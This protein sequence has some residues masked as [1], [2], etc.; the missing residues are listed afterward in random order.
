MEPTALFTVKL[1]LIAVREHDQR[2][3]RVAT[4]FRPA[5]TKRYRVGEGAGAFDAQSGRAPWAPPQTERPKEV[6]ATCLYVAWRL[7]G[8]G[9]RIA[10]GEPRF[11]DLIVEVVR[12]T[13]A[14]R[15][16]QRHDV[17]FNFVSDDE[18][19]TR[20]CCGG[21]TAKRFLREPPACLRPAWMDRAKGWSIPLASLWCTVY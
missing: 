1:D 14:Q 5:P 9:R 3:V 2:T 21:Q 13:E 19:M 6:H 15:V 4:D 16:G 18:R 10:S 8:E 11:P 7:Q 12:R 20:L 17:G